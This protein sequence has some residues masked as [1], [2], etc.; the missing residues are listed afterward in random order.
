MEL[1]KRSNVLDALNQPVKQ[2]CLTLVSRVK[3][4]ADYH[5]SMSKN[6]LEESR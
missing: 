2:F 1:A 6:T 3:W 5:I 4:W